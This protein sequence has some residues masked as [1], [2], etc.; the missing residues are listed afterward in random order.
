MTTPPPPVPPRGI[1]PM[2]PVP[3]PL[4]TGLIPP[5][6][7]PRTGEEPTTLNDGKPPRPPRKEDLRQSHPSNLTPSAAEV[8]LI[9]L[10]DDEATPLRSTREPEPENVY[11]T[12]FQRKRSLSSPQMFGL[13]PSRT[14]TVA[15]CPVSASVA[16]AVK[17]RQKLVSCGGE[18]AI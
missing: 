17:D 14:G 10:S 9:S 7:P 13:A 11:G 6:P 2:R 1:R 15:N 3:H 5:P 8:P 12:L 18:V 16:S 4:V